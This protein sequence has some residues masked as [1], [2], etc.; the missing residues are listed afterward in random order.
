MTENHDPVNHPVH[1]TW[2]PGEIEVINITECMNFNMGNAVKYILR[3][4]HKDEF[5]EDIRKAIWYL[6][7]ELKRRGY[8]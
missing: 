1:Y 4:D 5:E 7:R 3:S 2:L 8:E 6:K